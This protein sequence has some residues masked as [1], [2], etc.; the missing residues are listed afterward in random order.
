MIT[1]EEMI[2]D[3]RSTDEEMITDERW[4]LVKDDY[5]WREQH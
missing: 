5:W 2:T 1:D 3:E 4:L